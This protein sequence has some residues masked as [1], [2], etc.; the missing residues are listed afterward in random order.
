MEEINYL[1]FTSTSPQTFWSLRIYNVTHPVNSPSTSQRI[2]QELILYSVTQPPTPAFINAL[3]RKIDQRNR[4]E[5]PERNPHT[6]MVTLSLIK[7]A[8]IYSGQKTA[9]SING[10]GKTGQLHVK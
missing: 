8:R 5:S 3:L 10:A 1:M 4:I 7:E 2:V 6:Y 9:S